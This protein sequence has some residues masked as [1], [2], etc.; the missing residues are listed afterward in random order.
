ME[1]LPG[2]SSFARGLKFAVAVALVLAGLAGA[3]FVRAVLR[4]FDH[5]CEV[6]ASYGGRTVCREAVGATREEARTIAL[7]RACAFLTA[8]GEDRE[9]CLEAPPESADCREN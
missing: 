5:A 2:R 8:D 1:T 6:C 7:D 9:A 3:A 4:S